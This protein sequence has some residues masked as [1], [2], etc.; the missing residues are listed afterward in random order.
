MPFEA[1]LDHFD[2]VFQKLERCFAPPFPLQRAPHEE[3]RSP[4]CCSALLFRLLPRGLQELSGAVMLSL[5][6][7]WL[8]S[9]VSSLKKRQTPLRHAL[10]IIYEVYNCS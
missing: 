1:C 5:G 7:H 10:R 3:T 6:V 4:R 2:G 9:T 8:H